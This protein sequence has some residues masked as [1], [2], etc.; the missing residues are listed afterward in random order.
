MFIAEVD[1]QNTMHMIG[2]SCIFKIDN[3]IIILFFK[4][5]NVTAIRNC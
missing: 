1:I 4:S 5:K 2:Q 3:G